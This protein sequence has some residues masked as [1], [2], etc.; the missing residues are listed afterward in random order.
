MTVKSKLKT[1]INK[2][3]KEGKIDKKS[4]GAAIEAAMKLAEVMDDPDWPRIGKSIDNVTPATFLKYC[5]ALRIVPAEVLPEK[6][7]DDNE[8]VGHSK[9]KKTDPDES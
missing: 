2:A 6:K 9:W 3:V 7:S 1:A 5:T 4:H 8:L